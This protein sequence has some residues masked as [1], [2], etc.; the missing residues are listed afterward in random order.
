M[1]PPF[2]KQTTLKYLYWICRYL[3]SIVYVM[4]NGIDILLDSADSQLCRLKGGVSRYQ[5]QGSSTSQMASGCGSGEDWSLQTGLS[6]GHTS[7]GQETGDEQ[8]QEELGSD[9]GGTSGA[10]GGEDTALSL[11]ELTHDMLMLHNREMEK[12]LVSS[13]MEAKNFGPTKKLEQDTAEDAKDGDRESH[14]V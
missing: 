1:I 2:G 11:P 8:T 10:P 3:L 12:Q 13:F 9:K 14:P 4:M 6:A 5:G 7:G